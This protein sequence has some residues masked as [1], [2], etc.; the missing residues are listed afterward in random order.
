MLGKAFMSLVG[1]GMLRHDLAVRVEV[2]FFGK[3]HTSEKL[4][5][6]CPLTKRMRTGEVSNT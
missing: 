1:R 2:F 5:I 6:L 4:F 3:F